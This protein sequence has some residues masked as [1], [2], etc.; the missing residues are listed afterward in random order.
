MSILSCTDTVWLAAES[1]DRA[2]PLG[3]RLALLV[4]VCMCPPCARMRRHMQF[5]RDAARR[6]ES[7]AGEDGETAGLSS[8]GRVVVA[9][10][11]GNVRQPA[12]K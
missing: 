8:D 10:E 7:Q 1:L 6:L 2:L 3:Q 5:L 9:L 4:H 12:G 11:Q